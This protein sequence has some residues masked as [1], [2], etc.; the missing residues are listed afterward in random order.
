[1]NAIEFQATVKDGIIKVP[2]KYLR[3]ISTRVRVIL[4]AEESPKSRANLIDH[5]LAHPV[6]VQGFSPLK[7]EQIYAR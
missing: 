2:R 4:L 3:D 7:R 5:L 6:R 1:M